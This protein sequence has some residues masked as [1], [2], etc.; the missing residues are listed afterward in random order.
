M[1]QNSETFRRAKSA[2]IDME[3]NILYELGYEIQRLANSPHKFLLFFIKTL[4]CEKELGQTAWN[5]AN[6]AYLSTAPICY[7]PELLAAAAI[8]LAYRVTGLPMIRL[9]WW[10]LSEYSFELVSE[11]AKAIYEVSCVPLSSI[12]ECKRTLEAAATKKK[13]KD[14]S[15]ET[16]FDLMYKLT[17][18]Q[19]L[20]RALDRITKHRDSRSREAEKPEAKDRDKKKKRDKSKSRRSRSREQKKSKHKSSKDTKHRSKHYKT[21]KSKKRRRDSSSS[22]R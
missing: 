21:D 10:V 20:N 5:F 7:P 11:A 22:D 19:I 17:D 8:Y 2:V 14:Y 13:T 3:V 15:F 18:R 1:D 4:K 9:P 6:D 12:L 16:N